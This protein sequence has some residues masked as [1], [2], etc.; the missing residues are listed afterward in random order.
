MTDQELDRR[1][2]KMLW[3]VVRR[4]RGK[5]QDDD[6]VKDA[7]RGLMELISTQIEAAR[8]KDPLKCDFGHEVYGHRTSSGWCCACEADIAWLQGETEEAKTSVISAIYT[9][10]QE[11]ARADRTM[12]G[13]EELKGYHWFNAISAVQEQLASPDVD[14]EVA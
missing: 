2:E 11:F 1:L 12:I 5:K 13:S 4:A 6:Y 10:A 8:S 9:K 3:S 7:K 14:K